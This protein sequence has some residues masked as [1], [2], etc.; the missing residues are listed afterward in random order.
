[1]LALSFQTPAD[2]APSDDDGVEGAVRRALGEAQSVSG[3]FA[4]SPCA[5]RPLSAEAAARLAPPRPVRA[6]RWIAVTCRTADEAGHRTHLHE[7]CLTAAQRFMLSLSCDGVEN[8]WV[9]ETPSPEA[10]R[11]AGVDLG[12]TVPVGLIW[13]G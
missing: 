1:M 12:G 9:P 3:A 4:A 7:R 5:F 11:A 8:G 10:F 13:Y 2:P 6:G